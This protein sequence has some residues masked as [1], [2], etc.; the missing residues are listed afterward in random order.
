LL[1]KIQRTYAFTNANLL[2]AGQNTVSLTQTLVEGIV[3]STVT[4]HRGIILKF[5][6]PSKFY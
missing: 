1:F 3:M 2:K 4:Y 5:I 6:I